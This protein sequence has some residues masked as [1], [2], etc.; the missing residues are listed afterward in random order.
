MA[1]FDHGRNA[2]E[3][4]RMRELDRKGRARCKGGDLRGGQGAGEDADLV[5]VPHEIRCDMTNNG[6]RR[7]NYRGYGTCGVGGVER[8]V[9]VKLHQTVSKHSGQMMPG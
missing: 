5:D 6:S 8:S 7:R 9:H 2:C 3:M 4:V 1:P